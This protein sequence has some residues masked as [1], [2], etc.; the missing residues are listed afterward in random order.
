MISNA[1]WCR[2]C[3][4]ILKEGAFVADLSLAP[5]TAFQ[6][7]A[8]PGRYGHVV[9]G[10]RPVVIAE[11]PGLAVAQICARRGKTAELAATIRDTSGLELPGGP[12]RVASNGL[13][14]IG[15][16]PHEW[17]AVAE[18]ERGRAALARVK[19]AGKAFASF[20]VQ[21]HAKAILRVSGTRARD[22]LAKGC[23]LDLHE[24]AFKPGDAATTQVALIPCQLWQ[25]DESP[26]FE[27]SVPLGYAGSFWSWLSA[28][29]AEYGFEVKPPILDEA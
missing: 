5:R 20:V 10:D 7:L 8:L 25:L 14:I 24:R 22:A 9:G 17:L 19:E 27:L 11:R 4:S 13:A 18:G 29:A 15:M 2:Q 16:G 26:T 1:R 6:G 21:S 3:S 12:K 28:S 23:G